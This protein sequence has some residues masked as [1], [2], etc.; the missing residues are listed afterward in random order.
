MWLNIRERKDLI[1]Y[2]A[3]NDLMKMSVNQWYTQQIPIPKVPLIE[4]AKEKLLKDF[5]GFTFEV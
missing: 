3:D 2:T 4:K 5:E 1:D